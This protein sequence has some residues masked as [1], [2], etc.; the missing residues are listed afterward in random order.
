MSALWAGDVANAESQFKAVLRTEP[1]HVAALNLL[2]IVMIQGGRFAEAETYLRR[3][4]DISTNS[5]ATLC[6]YAVVLRAL[7]RPAEA[8]ER[9]S[10]ALKINP[11]APETWNGRGA[12]L[13][14]LQR[15]QDALPDFDRAIHLNP[16]YGEAFFNKA[17]TL[18]AIGRFDEAITSLDHAI[19][20][21]P[22]VVPVRMLRAKLLADLGRYEQALEAIDQLLALTPDLAEAWL[23]RTNILLGLKRYA[24]ALAACDR[25]LSLKPDLGEAWHGRGNVL[26][27]LKRRDESLIAYDKALALNPN[28]AGAWYGRANVLGEL[29]RPKEA[30]AAY[31]KALTISPTLA[32]AW[33]GRGNVLTELD[34]HDEAFAAFDRALSLQPGLAEA[35][36]GRG[37]TFLKL[38]RYGDALAA[39]ERALAGAG[40][41]AEA[42]LG[43]G[44][45]YFECNRRDEADV[46]YDRALALNPDLAEAWRGRG[47]VAYESRRF[48]AALA[49]YDKVL[50][51]KPSLKFVRG[52]R[53][54]AKLQ[55]CDWTNRDPGVADIGAST[56]AG[57]LEVAPFSFLA[58]S[59]SAADQ[60]QC[61]RTFVADQRPLTPVWR[62]E[63]YSHER[64]RLAYLSADFRN[65]AVGQLTVGLYEKHDKSRFETTAISFG[66]DD[67][68]PLRE[69]IKSA[70]DHFEDVGHMTDDEVAKLM[71]SREIDIAVDLMGFTRYCRFGI[72]ARRAAPVQVNYLGYPGTMGA[73]C[74]D[75]IIADPTVI[76]RDHQSFY[77][78]KVVWLPD[79]YQANDDKREISERVPPR[80]E[81]GLPEGAF[82]FCCFNNTFKI[83][84]EIFSMWMRLLAAKP[85]SVLWLL[86]ANA[87]VS[88]NLR[89][90]AEK[91]GVSPGRL[92]FAP[93]A[94][95]PDHLARH[96]N[97]DLFLDTLPYNAHTTASDALWAGVP[98][99][100][101]L[102]SAFAG[103]VAASLLRAV[104]LEELVTTS[105]PDYESLA[106]KLAGDP[107]YLA[108]VKERLAANRR[109]HPLFDTAK[110]TRHIETAYIVMW[111]RYQRGEGPQ[112]LVIDHSSL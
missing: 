71:R 43:Q 83:A 89:R 19:G 103:R 76:P 40:A 96:R 44:N 86:D 11:K 9:F 23:G 57:A 56:R 14:E 21:K 32:E 60:L 102:G 39:Y 18:L 104:G 107:N 53:L 84:P 30:I 78:E 100:T 91:R 75:Y 41:L 68:S 17:M 16:G 88:T 70:F 10:Q 90:E 35:W 61:A 111:E 45:V 97:A 7:K 55:L 58:F 65:Q 48:D 28:S 24:D 85:D 47:N 3:A 12:L 51:L 80:Q 110:F 46:A 54:H 69:R 26:D 29:K 25:A 106:L 20:I 99:V 66:P 27:A 50:K 59:S 74:V 8:L 34:L 95:L 38:G 77:G 33:N 105:L 109:T 72:V 15:P 67:R 98:L 92:I 112:A 64:I 73:G 31:D 81:C 108:S 4:L 94:P 63:I 5:D 52:D 13:N 87:T 101:C 36:L 49:A 37:N 82:V 1:R 93:R 42:W 79:A 6:N 22:D 2:G 62:G